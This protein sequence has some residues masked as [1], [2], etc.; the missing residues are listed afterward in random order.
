MTEGIIE[1]QTVHK[2]ALSPDK[3]K[4][5]AMKFLSNEN[6]VVIQEGLKTNTVFEIYRIE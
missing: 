5:V 2:I 6:P 4:E 3:F 1:V